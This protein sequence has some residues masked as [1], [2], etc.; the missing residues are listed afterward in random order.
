[1]R[2]KF[3]YWAEH[4][5][6]RLYAKNMDGRFKHVTKAAWR[7]AWCRLAAWRKRRGMRCR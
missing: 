1:M 5:A 7:F 2:L 6:Y 4:A 3:W